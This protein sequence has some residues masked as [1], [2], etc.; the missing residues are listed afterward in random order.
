MKKSILSSSIRAL[1]ISAMLCAMSVVI[2]AICKT[3]LNFSGGLFR[4]TFENLP[5]I[6][7]GILF[8]PLYGACVGV[9][10]D[11]LSYLMSSQEYPINIVVTMGAGII[12]FVSGIMSKYVLKSSGYRQIIFSAATAH[13]IGS[14]IIKS[15][16][17]YSYYGWAVMVRIPLY[18]IIASL[19]I[20]LMCMLYK[21]TAFR[22]LVERSRGDSL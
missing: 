15:I 7:A 16:G 17:L 21:N 8:G 22:R 2:G 6:L 3:T 11:I 20:G 5:I 19:E 12:G 9:I 1:T 10:S 14:V 4:I 18:L 13:L